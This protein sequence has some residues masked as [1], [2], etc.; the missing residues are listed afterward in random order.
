MIH[1]HPTQK[2]THIDSTPV[3]GIPYRI[4]VP[5]NKLSFINIESTPSA[6]LWTQDLDTP[7]KKKVRGG[8]RDRSLQPPLLD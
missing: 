3:D 8:L 7:V 5:D 4:F 2:Q 6:S 1:G